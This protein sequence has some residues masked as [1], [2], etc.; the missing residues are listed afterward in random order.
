M[1]GRLKFSYYRT[2]GVLAEKMQTFIVDK[3]E[4]AL[5]RETNALKIEGI[6]DKIDFFVQTHSRDPFPQLH[7]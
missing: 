1:C 5:N 6:K 7:I 4:I 2:T 3:I